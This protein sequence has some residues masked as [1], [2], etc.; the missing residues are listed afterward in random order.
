MY[1]SKPEKS[2]RKLSVGRDPFQK[3]S[4]CTVSKVNVLEA[5]EGAYCC[6]S[7]CFFQSGTLLFKKLSVPWK[8]GSPKKPKPTVKP[9]A[10]III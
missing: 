6:K 2:Q 7:R 3:C 9:M 10:L 1:F 4:E 5:F 8:I